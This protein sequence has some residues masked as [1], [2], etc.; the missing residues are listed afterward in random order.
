MPGQGLG[1]LGQ[2]HCIL[3]SAL[4][5]GDVT[6]ADQIGGNAFFETNVAAQPSGLLQQL[7]S[8]VQ[9]AGRVRGDPQ[10]AQRVGAGQS[11]A[12]VTAH[13]R[14]VM[15]RAA[16]TK[17]IASDRAPWPRTVANGGSL[18]SLSA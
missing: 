6:K 7:S 15:Q 12:T 3:G 10:V 4:G 13:L 2:A 5:R 11:I 14:G 16:S 18:P 1:F 17:L 9:V 8:R